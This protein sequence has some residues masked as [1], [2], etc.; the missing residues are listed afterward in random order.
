MSLE[1]VKPV[2]PVNYLQS[3][4]EGGGSQAAEQ[5]PNMVCRR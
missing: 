4:G 1:L 3:V 2:E 5:I